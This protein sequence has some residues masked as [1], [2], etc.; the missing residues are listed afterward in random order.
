MVLAWRVQVDWHL[1]DDS[2]RDRAW[3]GGALLVRVGHGVSLEL[4]CEYQRRRFDSGSN[5]RYTIDTAIEVSRWI[6][7]LLI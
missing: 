1:V 4:C 2:I 5:A 3:N 7:P 6:E